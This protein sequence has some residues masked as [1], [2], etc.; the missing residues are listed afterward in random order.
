MSES[1]IFCAKLGAVNDA[2]IENW[3]R[4]FFAEI[5][6]FPCP[7]IPSKMRPKNLSLMHFF[8][9]RCEPTATVISLKLMKWS[10]DSNKKV[11]LPKTWELV[12]RGKTTKALP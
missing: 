7:K 3:L 4:L 11:N 9:S 10:Q 12:L 2:V 8:E 6:A 5:L 1:D